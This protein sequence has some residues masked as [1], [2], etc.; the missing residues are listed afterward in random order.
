[1]TT[2]TR[3]NA[4]ISWLPSPH[5]PYEDRFRLLSHDVPL[6]AQKNAGEIYAVFDGVGSAPKGMAAAQA[7]ADCLVSYFQEPVVDLT[8]LLYDT[9]RAIHA[10][11]LMENSDRPLGACA[12]TV[13]SIK[14]NEVTF[15]HAGDTVGAL[16]RSNERPRILT[17]PQERGGAIYSYFGIGSGLKIEISRAA[18]QDDDLILLLTD[19]VT[20]A[21]HITDAAKM[22]LERYERTGSCATAISELVELSRRRGSVDDITALLVSI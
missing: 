11:G 2:E 21:F 16:L 19:G 17:S 10:W 12:G 20:K 15:L 18:L 14:G 7:M 4:A 1:M 6:V 13:A 22:V 9:N 3:G 8:N 5:H